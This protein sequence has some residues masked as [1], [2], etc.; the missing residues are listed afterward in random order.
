MHCDRS[1]IIVCCVTRYERVKRA[2]GLSVS[3][4]VILMEFTIGLS[5]TSHTIYEFML[6]SNSFFESDIILQVYVTDLERIQY[7][8]IFS[9]CFYLF[10]TFLCQTVDWYFHH[11]T[12]CIFIQEAR[13]ISMPVF[14]VAID[15][16]F[17]NSLHR[18]SVFK[19]CGNTVLFGS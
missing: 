7:C 8:N 14:A 10:S 15:R 9:Y 18:L 6:I 2:L 4:S 19:L 16:G 12:W 3:L 11:F 1:S 5:L 17:F 13:F